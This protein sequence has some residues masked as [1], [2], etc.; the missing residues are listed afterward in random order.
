MRG[1]IRNHRRVILNVVDEHDFVNVYVD[2]RYVGILVVEVHVR[3]YIIQSSSTRTCRIQRSYFE[4]LD[5]V[6]VEFHG[7]ELNGGD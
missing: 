1:K 2:I 4:T 5:R 7:V 3:G 6:E